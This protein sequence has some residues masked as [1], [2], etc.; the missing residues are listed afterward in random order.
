MSGLPCF[1]KYLQQQSKQYLLSMK[2]LGSS[3][4]MWEETWTWDALVTTC[5]IKARWSRPKDQQNKTGEF[6]SVYGVMY[7]IVNVN[8]RNK[9]GKKLR[10]WDKT[11][12]SGV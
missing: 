12:F 1:K 7:V 2:T 3:G 4:H 8:S 9:Q 6:L 11:L 10:K 5:R